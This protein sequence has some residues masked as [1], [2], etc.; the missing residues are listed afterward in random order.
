MDRRTFSV[1]QMQFVVTC[2]NGPVIKTSRGAG[3]NATL[4]AIAVAKVG[5]WKMK[6]ATSG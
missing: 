6:T 4:E 2:L 1:R 3:D 5:E